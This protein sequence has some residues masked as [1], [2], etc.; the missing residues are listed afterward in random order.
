MNSPKIV[1]LIQASN[2]I[3]AL[4]EALS[5]HKFNHTDV[6]AE[7]DYICYDIDNLKRH[8]QALATN[9][10]PNW[11]TD[12]DIIMLGTGDESCFVCCIPD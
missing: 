11:F 3:I 6:L 7:C 1:D 5:Y 10:Y 4:D 9:Y 8:I 2:D 12:T